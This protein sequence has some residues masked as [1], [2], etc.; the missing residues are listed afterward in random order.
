MKRVLVVDDDPDM[1]E[2]LC[3]HLEE[4]GYRAEP[5]CNGSDALKKHQ[6][7]DC[8]LAVVDIFMPDKDGLETIAALRQQQPRLPILAISGGGSFPPTPWLSVARRLGADNI[9]EKPFTSEAFL[10]SVKALLETKSDA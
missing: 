2:L 4:A 9:L 1:R 6:Q 7:R 10:A 3:A 5:A 8:S